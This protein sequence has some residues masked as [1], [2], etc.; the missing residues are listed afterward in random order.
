M[1]VFI[2]YAHEQRDQADEIAYALRVRG[3]RVFLDHDHL[4]AGQEYRT[5]IYS[6]IQASDFF[7]FLVSP[8]SLDSTRYARTELEIAASRWM[9]LSARLLP[10]QVAAVDPLSLPRAISASVHMLIPIGNVAEAVVASIN[11][12]CG[13]HARRSITIAASLGFFSAALSAFL[14]LLSG[15]SGASAPDWLFLKMNSSVTATQQ[16]VAAYVAIPFALVIGRIAYASGNRSLWEFAISAMFAVLAAYGAM[17]VSVQIG[18]YTTVI[19]EGI[20]PRAFPANVGVVNA[21]VIASLIPGAIGAI[22]TW[23]GVVCANLRARSVIGGLATLAV[24]AIIGTGDLLAPALLTHAYGR[25]VGIYGTDI[26]MLVW[27]PAVAAMIAYCLS[28]R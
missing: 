20:S 27:Q 5:R 8:Q 25:D 1:I 18:P 11:A 6:E 2:S 16:E 9:N 21:A 26:V 13:T 12:M 4:A 10:V 28:P 14:M 17:W 23:F 24:G 7:I 22:V 15:R 19:N 3:H